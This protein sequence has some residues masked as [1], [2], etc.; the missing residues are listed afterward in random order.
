MVGTFK[1]R[2]GLGKQWLRKDVV[3]RDQFMQKFE[4]TCTRE[5]RMQKDSEWEIRLRTSRGGS[6]RLQLYMV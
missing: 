6:M 4:D 1:E 3:G 2:Q 5:H